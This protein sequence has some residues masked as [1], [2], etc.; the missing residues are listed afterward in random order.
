MLAEEILFIPVSLGLS[1]CDGL[2]LPREHPAQFRTAEVMSIILTRTEFI[3]DANV[4]NV[5]KLL[6]SRSILVSLK[7]N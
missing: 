2:P 5:D 1:E 7:G 4:A 3:L 6:R